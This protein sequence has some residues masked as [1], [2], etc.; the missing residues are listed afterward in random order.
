VPKSATGCIEAQ[1]GKTRVAVESVPQSS[2][3]VVVASEYGLMQSAAVGSQSV[4][5]VDDATGRIDV[6]GDVAVAIEVDDD[7][8][9][10]DAVENAADA[11]VVTRTLR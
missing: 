5:T 1:G 7:L 10:L 11:S 9:Q 6:A 3:R 8:V 2:Q 4:A